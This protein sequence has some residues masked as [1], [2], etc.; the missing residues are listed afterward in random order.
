MK[1]N[2]KNINPIWGSNFNK[3]SNPLLEK[4]NSSIDFDK[5]LALQDL[6]VSEVHSF[7]LKRKKIISPSEYKL[8]IKGLKKI[9]NLIINKKFKFN[10]KYEDIHMN[11]EVELKRLIG[12]AAEKLHTARSRND[13]VAT[14]FKLWIIEASKKLCN[15]INNLQ[16]TIV[17]KANLNIK[18]IFPGFT[19]LQSAQ[20]VSFAHHLMAYYE[21]F[22]RD[23]E[24]LSNSVTR[25]NECPLGSAALAGTTFEID[26]NL[27]SK[28]LG[29]NKPSSNSMDS[30]S[31]RDYALEFLSNIAICGTHLS[32]FGEDIT[33]WA[34]DQFKF[35]TL[36][37]DFSTGSSIMPQ[38]KNP[39][40]AELIRGKMGRLSGNF[41]SL[42][43]TIKGLPLTYSKDLQEDKEPV[44]D[45]FDNLL[46][47]IEVANGIVNGFKI[48][49]NEMLN[50]CKKGNLMA[51]D[52]AD[53]IVINYNIPF[54]ESYKITAK[55][56]NIA[57]KKNYQINDLSENDLN[58]M[59]ND[60][61]RKI[62][63]FLKIENSINYK[64]SIGST[65]PKEIRKA[66]QVAKKELY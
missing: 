43:T 2:K 44:F 45:S 22:K 55:I 33:L 40:S 63:K 3:Q 10:K 36:S 35:I 8:I 4:I 25:M 9:K 24:R 53:W 17:K 1:K 7:M 52:L 31:D 48:N 16:K 65:S 12:D 6:K 51:T 19:H 23:K 64:K 42:L 50:A 32:R 62:K 29:F 61:G 26:R 60:S 59:G 57:N 49:K 14:D 39:D 30:V 37:D 11:I 56:I 27:T 13:Q 21:M 46:L 38:K 5:R 15:E 34:S 20:I 58:V 41:I 28:M 18:T 54:R 66:I 47:S